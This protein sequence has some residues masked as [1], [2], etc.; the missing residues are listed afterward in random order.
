MIK[1]KGQMETNE[2]K[3]RGAS[4]IEDDACVPQP[5]MEGTCVVSGIRSRSG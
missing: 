3:E 2:V 1:S 5:R 4:E